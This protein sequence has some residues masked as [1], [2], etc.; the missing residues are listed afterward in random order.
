MYDFDKIIDR[1][2]TGS[3]KFDFAKERGKN[4]DELSLW[5]ADMDFQVAKPITDAL[6]A[7][8]NQLEIQVTSL[9]RNR[10]IGN[11]QP[12]SK[13]GY[14]YTSYKFYDAKSPLIP[15]GL[16]GPVKLQVRK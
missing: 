14:T 12:D 9:W 4:G 6:Q 15:A 3:L 7:G 13:Q 1:H 10:I 16:V 8:D 5:V 2:G 11:Q